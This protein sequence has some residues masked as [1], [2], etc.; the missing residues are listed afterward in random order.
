MDKQHYDNFVNNV[1]LPPLLRMIEDNFP[2][3]PEEAKM[4]FYKS[5][6]YKLLLIESMKYWQYNTLTLFNM[7]KNGLDTGSFV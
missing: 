6:I 3:N 4:R 7:F 1:I 5:P 2:K